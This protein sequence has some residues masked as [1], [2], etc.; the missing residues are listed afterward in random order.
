MSLVSTTPPV[1]GTELGYAEITSSF[2]TT[3]TSFVDVTGLTTTVTVGARPILVV[4]FTNGFS[5]PG[6]YG[7]SVILKE[8]STELGAIMTTLQTAAHPGMGMRRLAPSAGSHTYLIRAKSVSAGTT[9][10]AAGTGASNST[11]MPA[12]IQVLEI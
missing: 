10:I 6:T 1:M 9:T 3:S 12:Y 2:S 7:A 4:L 11:N 8:D 5:G